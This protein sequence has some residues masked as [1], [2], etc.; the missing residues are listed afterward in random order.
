M[1]RSPIRRDGPGARKFAASRSTLKPRSA[2]KINQSNAEAAFKRQ[3]IMDRGPQCEAAAIHA[4][5][6][7][8]CFGP[9]DKHEIVTRARGGD[10]LDPANVVL[11]CRS[12]HDWAHDHPTEATR[13]GLL[14]SAP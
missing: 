2:K 1:R 10:P 6:G 3:L 12:I 14:A 5:I 11:V 4:E 13:L 9:V 7:V 8:P